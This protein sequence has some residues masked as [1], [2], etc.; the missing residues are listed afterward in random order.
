MYIVHGNLRPIL[1]ILN[2]IPYIFSS[3]YSMG[4]ADM[5]IR[6]NVQNNIRKL[7]YTNYNVPF[8]TIFNL[9]PPVDAMQS[10]W[11]ALP[12]FWQSSNRMYLCVWIT[13]ICIVI[14]IQQ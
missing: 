9:Y 5:I 7:Q 13:M 1:C 14:V 6:I 8:Y 11:R 4:Y 12:L 2:H 3:I 10:I